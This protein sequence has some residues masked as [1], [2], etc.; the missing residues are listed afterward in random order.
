VRVPTKAA[1]D[2]LESDPGV[3]LD[4]FLAER[5]G[6]GSVERMRRGMSNAEWLTW[7]VYYARKAQR[8]QLAAGG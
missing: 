3:E 1:Y 6:W 5:L 7:S 4:F 8:R 2:L